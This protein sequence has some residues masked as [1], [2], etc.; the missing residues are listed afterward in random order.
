LES[1]LP[2]NHALLLH[3]AELELQLADAIDLRPEILVNASC[4]RILSVDE[5]VGSG[6]KVSPVC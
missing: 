3:S 1:Q 2:A 5:K 4:Q 6:Q